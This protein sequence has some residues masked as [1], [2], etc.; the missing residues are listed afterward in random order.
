MLARRGMPVWI[1]LVLAIGASAAASGPRFTVTRADGTRLVG[2]DIAA[3]HS[4]ESVPTLDGQP[5]FDPAN[6]VVLV[7][8]ESLPPPRLPPTF[9]EFWLGDRLPGRVTAF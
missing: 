7:R 3:W 6:P 9:V 5:L 1:A 8:D 4:P 2:T